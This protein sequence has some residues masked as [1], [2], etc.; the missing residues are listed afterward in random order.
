MFTISF[1]LI[2]QL[3]K[4]RIGTLRS[5]DAMQRERRIKSDF[6]FFQSLP[7]LFLPTSFVQCGQALLDLN[8]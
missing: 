6:A 5:N 4:L 1:V 2:K 7:Q 3:G 8:S